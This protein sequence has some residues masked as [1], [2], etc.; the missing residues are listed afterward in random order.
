MEF[1]RKLQE[2]EKNKN[3]GNKVGSINGSVRTNAPPGVA[4]RDE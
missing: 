3:S 1:F 2:K 4:T